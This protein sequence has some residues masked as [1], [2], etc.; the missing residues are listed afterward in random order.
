MMTSEIA[1]ATG[2]REVACPFGTEIDDVVIDSRAA[3]RNALFVAIKGQRVDGHDFVAQAAAAGAIS[4]VERAVEAPHIL[5]DD[6]VA[7]LGRLARAVYD[8]SRATVIGITGSSG[9]TTTKDLLGQVL[10]GHADT[11]ATESSFNNE[12]GLPLTVCRLT[13]DTRYLVLEM[14]ARDIGH[15]SYLTG[16]AP[17]DVAVVLNVGVAHIGV[18]GSRERIAQAKGELVEALPPGGL[19]VLNADDAYVA[20]MASRTSARVIRY[21]NAQGADYRAQDVRLDA[22]GRARFQLQTPRG[23]A[24][25]ALKVVGEHM[26]ADALA[27]AAVACELGM[28]VDVTAAALTSAEA[29]SRWRMDV[30][31]TGSGVTIVNDAYNANTESMIAALKA[32]KSMSRGGRGWAVLG[33]MA[34]LGERTVDEHVRVGQMV[35]RLGIDR[36][37][38][39]GAGAKVVYDTF[40]VEGSLPDDARHVDTVDEAVGFLTA[41]LREGDVVLVKASRSAGLERIAL[42]LAPDGGMS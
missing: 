36:L 22:G 11:I 14:S 39:V 7:A 27:A 15:I 5:V 35:V 18:F 34:E 20:A 19:A 26:V 8:R 33:P 28:P 23:A 16:L 29:M 37:V 6:S 42:A 9:K 32:L 2:A 3:R 1:A 41:E 10:A 24:D 21:G 40:I 13:S 17:P 38:T 12:I 4:L 25:V 30:R 31:T